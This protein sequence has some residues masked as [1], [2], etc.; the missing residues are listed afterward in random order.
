M[1]KMTVCIVFVLGILLSGCYMDDAKN[2]VKDS[3][4]M[5]LLILL[6]SQ[7]SWRCS[8]GMLQLCSGI[9]CQD[10]QDCGSIGMTCSED[11]GDCLGYVGM[12]CCN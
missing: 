1:S 8:G 7:T 3:K 6:T 10:Y 12:A 2:A 11:P 5:E 9:S 4:N